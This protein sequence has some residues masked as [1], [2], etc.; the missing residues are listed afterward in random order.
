MNDSVPGA[1]LLHELQIK[2]YQRMVTNQ[3][4]GVGADGRLQP[5]EK[6]YHLISELSPYYRSEIDKLVASSKLKGKSGSRENL[7]SDLC[8]SALRTLIILNR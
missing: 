1:C 5:M 3:L 8:E 4:V 7:V 2:E 6:Y